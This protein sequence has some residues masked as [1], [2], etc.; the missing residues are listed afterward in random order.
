MGVASFVQKPI[1]IGKHENSNILKCIS[2]YD[3][4]IINRMINNKYFT[5]IMEFY[6]LK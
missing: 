4:I 5:Q 1:M 2:H 3:N 6:C